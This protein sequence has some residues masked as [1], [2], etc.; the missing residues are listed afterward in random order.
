MIRRYKK[1]TVKIPIGCWCINPKTKH[2]CQFYNT[3]GNIFENISE[4]RCG[5]Y[6]KIWLVDEKMPIKLLCCWN[7]GSKPINEEEHKEDG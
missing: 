7:D 5:Y 3:P 1:V 6:D 2:M 4:S